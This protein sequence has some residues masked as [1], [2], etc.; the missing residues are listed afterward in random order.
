MISQYLEGLLLCLAWTA[1]PKYSY[2]DYEPESNQPVPLP[3][4][5]SIRRRVGNRTGRSLETAGP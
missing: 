5:A 3:A 2:S 4:M 1:Y